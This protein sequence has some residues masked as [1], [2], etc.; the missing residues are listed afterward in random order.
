MKEYEIRTRVVVLDEQELSV[1]E[2]ELI[3]AARKATESS[4][5]PYS[6]FQVGVALQL[7]DGEIILGSN[8]ENA[9]YP[10]GTCAERTAL[11]WCGANRSDAVIT[12][13]AIAAQTKGRFTPTPISPC[14]MCRQALLETEHRQGF[15]IR[16]LL[17]GGHG[18][19]CIDS[20]KDLMPLS[21]S[22]DSMD[23]ELNMS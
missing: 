3:G 17:Y 19:H 23:V 4:Y 21:F 20:V 2:Q 13:I 1:A 5:S 16:V 14:G 11:F 22:A 15:P 18:T 12:A 9:S 10:V 8:Q 7:Q 6:H